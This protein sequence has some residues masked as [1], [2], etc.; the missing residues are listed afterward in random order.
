MTTAVVLFNLG[1]PDSLSAVQP[2]LYNLFKDKA[3][4][5]LPAFLRLPLAWF[6][7][8]KRSPKA[9]S[10]YA[11]LGGKSPLLENTT[12]QANA[13]EKT[14]GAGY[15]VFIAMRYWHPMTLEVVNTVKTL[16]PDA[17][18]LLPLYPQCS[19]TTTLSSIRAWH[20]A[21]QKVGLTAPTRTICCYPV[22]PHWI[23][24]I[25]ETIIQS[26]IDTAVTRIIFS[27]H[28]LPQKI[29]DAGDPYQWQVEQTVARVVQRL[30][31]KNYTIAYQS[32]VGPLKWLTPS[33]DEAFH[34]AAQDNVPI[35][36]VP[37]AFVSEHSET[38]VELDIDYAHLAKKLGIPSYHR[39]NTVYLN[40]HF[41]NALKELVLNTT[42][43]SRCCP[44]IFKDC[45][46]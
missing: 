4:I 38:L 45:P 13:L 2:F 7:S 25:A 1:A 11:T 31:I 33:L 36:V 30:D 43:P 28:G 35:A 9:S 10:I 8:T 18:V 46:L 16:N 27:A 24:S 26:G 6:I 5:R 32:R 34:Q 37:I 20:Q 44:A 41:I 40:E 17:I 29:V 39:I 14:L 23:E 22:H 15:K 42:E 21:A 12:H 3:I 19:S